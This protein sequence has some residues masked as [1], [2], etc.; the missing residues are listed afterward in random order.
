M[1]SAQLAAQI[2]RLDRALDELHRAVVHADSALLHLKTELE[3]EPAQTTKPD[4]TAKDA[5]K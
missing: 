1:T 4:Q 2:A 3:L 5:V